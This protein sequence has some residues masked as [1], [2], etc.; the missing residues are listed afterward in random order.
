MRPLLFICV[1][2]LLL[3]THTARATNWHCYYTNCLYVFVPQVV[4]GVTVTTARVELEYLCRAERYG[5]VTNTTVAGRSTHALAP[6]PG[7]FG[8]YVYFGAQ[9]HRLWEPFDVGVA[10]VTLAQCG[11]SAP[12]QLARSTVNYQQ[13]GGIVRA[14]GPPSTAKRVEERVAEAARQ[15]QKAV[16]AHAGAARTNAVLFI[17]QWGYVS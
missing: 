13:R 12:W 8:A 7:G 11:T 10:I 2:V 16:Q 4:A 14:C 5:A 3:A 9:Q 17:A 1:L 6:C 15:L